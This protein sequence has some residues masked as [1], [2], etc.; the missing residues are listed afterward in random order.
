M[1]K[2]KIGYLG[3]GV[4]LLVLNIFI[5]APKIQAAAI[6]VSPS[7][8]DVE[9][10]VG[11]KSDQY[12]NI[13]RSETTG[14]MVFDVELGDGVDF[15]GLLDQTEV[16]ILDGENLIPFNFK[17]D[18]TDLELGEY[19]NVIRFI[20]QESRASSEGGNS[21]R[22]GVTAKI[23]VHVVEELSESLD[24]T[25]DFSRAEN[26]KELISIKSF[27][28]DFD[29][30]DKELVLN[31]K[32]KNISE[33]PLINTNFQFNVFCEG[34]EFLSKSVSIG[35]VFE[36]GETGEIYHEYS[37]SNLPSGLCL[38]KTL[39]GEE[40]I[41]SRFFAISEKASLNIKIG[42]LALSILAVIAAVVSRIKFLKGKNKKT[43]KPKKS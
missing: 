20:M 22:Y 35:D 5:L 40:E 16:T 4:F 36:S 1:K 10:L 27:S 42:L 17:I 19:E 43:E 41:K 8:L 38:A 11:Q 6:G 30:K 7:E 9:V 24:T 14:E 34:R 12:F 18:A 29:L 37:L 15:F 21:V 32:V 23:K 39:V 2:N 33:F 26:K 28:S 31:W 3:F 13:S 25:V